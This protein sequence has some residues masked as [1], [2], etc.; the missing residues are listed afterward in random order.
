MNKSGS[1]INNNMNNS[2]KTIPE[3]TSNKHQNTAKLH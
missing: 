1:A 3:S 2:G